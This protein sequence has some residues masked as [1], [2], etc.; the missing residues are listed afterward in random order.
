MKSE[1]K[2]VDALASRF[3]GIPNQG[4][5]VP[6][7]EPRN[8][9]QNPIY[10]V[11][12]KNAIQRFKTP[13]NRFKVNQFD[14]SLNNLEHRA[15]S[16]YSSVLRK[17]Q[18]FYFEDVKPNI[19][20]NKGLRPR[21]ISDYELKNPRRRPVKGLLFISET[22]PHKYMNFNRVDRREAQIRNWG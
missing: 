10:P 2:R 16:F 14:E 9:I 12:K 20:V 7:K 8:N 11:I 21:H 19:F 1:Y 6:I 3:R 4:V 17:N 22:T 5:I 18:Q 13:T 15:N